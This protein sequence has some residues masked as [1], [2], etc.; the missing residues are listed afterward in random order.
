MY[1]FLRSRNSS[2]LDFISF[3]HMIYKLEIIV[4]LTNELNESPA[5]PFGLI[6]SNKVN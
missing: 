4:T 2:V 1:L 3:I 6:A 5:K